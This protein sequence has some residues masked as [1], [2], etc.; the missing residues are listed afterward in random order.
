MEEPLLLPVLQ[1]VA[2][3]SGIAIG[4]LDTTYYVGH[5]TIVVRDEAATLNRIPQAIFSYL[6]HNAVHEERRYGIPMDQVVELG[7][8]I[9]ISSKSAANMPGSAAATATI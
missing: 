2:K 9:Q 6:N 7:A 1:Q 4:T 3:E 8:Q 5:E